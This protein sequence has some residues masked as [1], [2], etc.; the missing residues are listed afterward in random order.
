MKIIVLTLLAFF[1]HP[2]SAQDYM[3]PT[4]VFKETWGSFQARESEQCPIQKSALNFGTDLS[5]GVQTQISCQLKCKNQEQSKVHQ[6]SLAFHPSHQNLRKGD[7]GLWASL[8]STLDYWS[9]D[10][11]FQFAAQT[12]QGLEQIEEAERLAVSSGQWSLSNSLKCSKDQTIVLSPFEKTI[13][14]NPIVNFDHL[15]NQKQNQQL[16]DLTA[17]WRQEF[18]FGYRDEEA[19]QTT[20]DCQNP[21]KATFC[22]GDCISLDT[23]V[24]QEYLATPNP[25]GSDDYMTCADDLLERIKDLNLPASIKTHLCETQFMFELKSRS[26]TGLTC[27][28]SRLDSECALVMNKP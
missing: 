10:Q 8:T 24:W 26:V 21:V 13:K 27:A 12:C 28:S 17:N 22:Y 20:S 18:G 19:K 3:M 4:N 9:K 5:Q 16:V 11:C 23:E 15:K 1:T 2:L 25:L 7:G 14:T 6:L